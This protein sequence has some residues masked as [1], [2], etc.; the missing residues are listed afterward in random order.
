MVPPLQKGK[1]EVSALQDSELALQLPECRLL[2]AHIEGWGSC[3]SRIKELPHFMD[4]LVKM[5][6][7]QDPSLH[8]SLLQR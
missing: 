1:A 8:L 4:A 7:R 5:L 6:Y 2:R 3:C